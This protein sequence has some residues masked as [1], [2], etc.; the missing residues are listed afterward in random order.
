MGR[1]E[2][3][4]DRPVESGITGLVDHTHS[5]LAA[6]L[7]DFVVGYGFA[8]HESSPDTLHILILYHTHKSIHEL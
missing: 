7:E 8:D 1:E 5:A 3:Y 4:R 2:L 6:L